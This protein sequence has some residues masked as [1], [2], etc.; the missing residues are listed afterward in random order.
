[1]SLKY[2]P[3]CCVDCQHLFS[4]RRS[5]LTT[6]S[7]QSDESRLESPRKQVTT[8]VVQPDAAP[9][10]SIIVLTNSL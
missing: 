4:E 10:R 7:V 1:M 3:A 6:E 2:E 9:P 5:V 8:Q